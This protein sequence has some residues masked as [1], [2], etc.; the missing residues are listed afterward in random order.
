MH[1]LHLALLLFA[2]VNVQAQSV[3]TLRTA[4]G[5]PFALKGHIAAPL[6]DGK[7]FVY[8]A[9]PTPFIRDKQGELITT[10]RNRREGPNAET[11]HLEPLLWDPQKRGWKR[12]APAP[13]CSGFRYLHTATVLPDARVLI[14]GGLCDTPKLRDDPAPHPAHASLSLW[15]AATAGWEAAPRL[16]DA[17]IYHSA[18]LM[19]DGAVLIVGGESDPALRGPGE[20]VLGSVESFRNGKLTRLAPLRT[21]RAKHTATPLADGS[22]LVAGGFD[23]AGKAI[24]SVEIRDAA[25]QSWR[26]AP[27]LATA[28]HSHSATLLDDGRVLI[29]GGIDR[30][31]RPLRSVE[32]WDPAATTASAGVDLPTSLYGHAAAVLKNGNVLVGGGTAAYDTLPRT[33]GWIRDKATGEWKGAGYAQPEVERELSHT[34]TLWPREDGT[35]YAFT[36]RH[37]LRWSPGA[38]ARGTPMWFTPPAVAALSD[39]RVMAVA[40]TS[41]GAEA[42]WQAHI[43]DPRN[44]SWIEAGTLEYTAGRH[45]QA[46]QLASGR[47]IHLGFGGRNLVRC[48]MWQPSDNT[49]EW[50]GQFVMTYRPDTPWGLERVGDGRVVL[51][52][53]GSEAF[54]FDEKT[55]RWTRSKPEWNYEGLTYGAPIRPVNPLVRIFDE[56]NKQWLDISEVGSRLW[57][58]LHGRR[59]YDVKIDDKTVERFEGRPAPPSLLW[60]PRNARWAYIFMVG[61]MGTHAQV[62]PDGCALSWTPFTLFDPSTGKVRAL[63]EPVTGIA[64]RQ[65]SMVVLADGTVVIAGMPDGALAPG[66]GFFHRKASCAGFEALP[67]D[68]ALMP[69]VLYKEQTPASVAPVSEPAASISWHTRVL[70]AAS[71]HRW[72]ILA[73][74]TPFMIYVLLRRVILPPLRRASARALPEKATATL[75]RTLPKPFAWGTRVVVYGIAGVIFLI[76]LVPYLRFKAATTPN[77]CEEDAAACIDRRTGILKGAGSKLPCAYIGDWSSRRKGSPMFRITLK[78]DGTYLMVAGESQVNRERYT[79]FWAVQGENMVWRHNLAQPQALDVNR[80]LPE[81]DSR[82]ALVEENGSHTQFE[83]IQAV[84][85]NRCTP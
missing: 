7:V 3:G 46:I 65:G 38:P 4:G 34:V 42:V 35:A 11:P 77:A 18:T 75:T 73:V 8:G 62:L 64:S 32:L 9:D 21:A 69:A 74:L 43:W 24:A 13:E 33:W 36:A 17:R 47:V 15:N 81:S 61:T 5:Y 78:D 53:S 66:A 52:S 60:D 49:W 63:G 85:S 27:S 82:F 29:A 1:A 12:I 19:K 84:Q 71:E 51:I 6:P 37:I 57:Q 59:T 50:C 44:D 20:P 76:L 31:G 72:I 68:S 14:A 67:G 80:I 10:L 41:T 55:G 48:E 22:L 39:G 79:G 45:T 16:H 28:R 23:D 56:A 40:A 83:R 70:G 2:A 26:D 25:G 58:S 54:L 30:D